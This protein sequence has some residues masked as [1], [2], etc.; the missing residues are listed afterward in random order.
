[1]YAG[2]VESSRLHIHCI[3]KLVLTSSV[4]LTVAVMNYRYQL[5]LADDV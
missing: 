1:M 3:G 4:M 5:S 2:P